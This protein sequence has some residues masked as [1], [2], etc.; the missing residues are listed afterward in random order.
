MELKLEALTGHAKSAKVGKINVNVGDRVEENT[1]LLQL[2]TGKGNSPIKAKGTYNIEDVKVNEGDEVKIG[3]ILMIVSEEAKPQNKKANFDYFGSMIKGKNEKIET[4]LAIIGSGP[5]GY[6]SAI[7][8]A[9]KG[10]KVVIIEKENLGINL[11]VYEELSQ[12]IDCIIHS[13]ANA[14]H[15]GKYAD[16]FETNVKGTRMVLEFCKNGRKKDF[17]HISTFAVFGNRRSNC[18]K[19]LITE[20]DLEIGQECRAHGLH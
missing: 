7:Y 1:V 8:A 9:K 12:K 18:N 5:G 2:E 20:Y 17:Q 16:F 4:D 14:S 3:D 15:Y 10:L 6:V 13:A 19:R 11:N